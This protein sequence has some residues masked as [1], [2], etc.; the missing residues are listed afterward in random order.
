MGKW[1]QHMDENF[2][3]IYDVYTLQ[4]KNNSFPSLSSLLVLNDISPSVTRNQFL[5]VFLQSKITLL[6]GCLYFCSLVVDAILCMSTFSRLQNKLGSSSEGNVI[7]L[8]FL[9]IFN[10][11]S[12]VPILEL[13]GFMLYK[14]QCL[15]TTKQRIQATRFYLPTCDWIILIR[16]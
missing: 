10:Y 7:S 3:P 5:L 6:F 13:S 2:K 9:L 12:V 11:V 16:W 4:R 8:T 15:I 1:K 14:K